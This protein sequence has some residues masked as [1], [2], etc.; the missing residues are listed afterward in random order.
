MAGVICS[1]GFSLLEALIASLLIAVAVVGLAQLVAVGTTQSG[2]ARRAVTAVTL[3]QAKLEELRAEPWG[4]TRAGSRISSG[5]LAV[6]T[7][8]DLSEDRPGHADALDRFGAPVSA[9]DPPHF[10]RRW[11]IELFD[12]ADPDTLMLSVCVFDA[13]GAAAASGDACVWAIRARK[14]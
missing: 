1:R 2:R 7:G 12:P 4:Y 9:G 14:P 5:A 10:R 6:S 11:A 8:A 3:A 13:G